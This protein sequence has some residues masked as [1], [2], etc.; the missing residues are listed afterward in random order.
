MVLTFCEAS[1]TSM[2][3]T[4]FSGPLK[5]V[6]LGMH[7]SLIA[8]VCAVLNNWDEQDYV[9][10]TEEIVFRTELSMAGRLFQLFFNKDI[11][12]SI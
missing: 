12:C 10:H 8:A 7:P 11:F 9:E 1:A 5:E 2:V 6:S 3:N 4:V